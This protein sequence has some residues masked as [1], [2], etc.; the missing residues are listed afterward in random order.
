MISGMGRSA[1]EVGETEHIAVQLVAEQ[2]AT[3]GYSWREIA[4]KA[5]IGRTRLAA[6]FNG[7]R[8]ITLEEFVR[9]CDLARL[10]VRDVISRAREQAR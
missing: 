5:D 8:T 9:L 7:E 4:T 2:L 10:D 6:I 3:L 1:L